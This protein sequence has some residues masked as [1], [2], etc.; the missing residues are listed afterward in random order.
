[1]DQQPSPAAPAEGGDM[2]QQPSPAARPSVVTTIAIVLFV[3]GGLSILG[4]LVA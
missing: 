1:M 2:D 3:R 4:G